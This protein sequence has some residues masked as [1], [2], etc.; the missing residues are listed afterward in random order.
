MNRKLNMMRFNK[1][2][3]CATL[4]LLFFKFSGSGVIGF[5][6]MQRLGLAFIKEN[7]MYEAELTQAELGRINKLQA[8]YDALKASRE[9]CLGVLRIVTAHSECDRCVTLAKQALKEAGEIK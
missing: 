1:K 5:R 3:N 8:K 7:K 4:P 2:W 9:K 6:K